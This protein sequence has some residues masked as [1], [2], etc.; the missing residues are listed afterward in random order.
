MI[1]FIRQR[2]LRFSTAM[3]ACTCV[4]VNLCT[5]TE[6]VTASDNIHKQN[7]DYTESKD[8]I[9]NPDQGFY[10]PLYVTM[11]PKGVVYDT[12]T[13]IDEFQL[14][15]LRIDI[16]AFS[17]KVNGKED[18]PFTDVAL[19]QLDALLST[20]NKKEKNAIINESG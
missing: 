17:K 5:N 4:L 16:S 6:I 14:Y 15:H 3:I 18:I 13:I 8:V 19:K 7:L 1:F 9:N 20:L 2:L 10:E 12:D 11:T